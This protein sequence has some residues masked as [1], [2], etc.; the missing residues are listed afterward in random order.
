MV[1]IDNGDIR[2]TR[3]VHRQLNIEVESLGHLGMSYDLHLH[4][5]SRNTTWSY[6]LR[7]VWTNN[8]CEAPDLISSRQKKTCFSEWVSSAVTLD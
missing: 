6:R 4:V 8:F 1:V 2:S 3:R 7:I 5:Q